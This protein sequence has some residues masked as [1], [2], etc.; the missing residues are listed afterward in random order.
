[1]STFY[2]LPPR[3]CMEQ[4]AA[5]FVARVLPGVP[6]PATLWEDLLGLLVAG[7]PETFFVHR[8]DLPGD[9]EL[10]EDLAI[11]FGA[12]PGDV[13][14]E[15]GLAA[16]PAPARVRRWSVPAAVSNPGSGR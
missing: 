12:E 7:C 2:V 5:A 6:A 15:V 13:V 9:G 8:E 3:E 1:M 11:G 4:A 14:A 10:A 16:G